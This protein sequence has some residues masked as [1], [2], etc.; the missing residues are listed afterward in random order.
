MSFLDKLKVKVEENKDTSEIKDGKVDKSAGFMQLEVDI[1]QTASDIFVIAP[2]PGVDIKDVDISIENENDVVT[3]QGKKD[4]PAVTELS[5][6]KDDDSKFL[7]Q[8][9]KWGL[10]YRQIIL[11][12]EINVAE[13]EAK[14]KKGIL[15]LRLPMLL[16]QTKGKKKITIN[17]A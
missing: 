5:E 4:R 15:I 1:F 17:N 11:P 16:L 6:E 9:C 12:Q 10:F 8:E 7:R 13:V 14:F 3:I 2:M